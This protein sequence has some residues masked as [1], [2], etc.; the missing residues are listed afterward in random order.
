MTLSLSIFNIIKQRKIFMSFAMTRH[1]TAYFL[2]KL[3]KIS[4]YLSAQEILT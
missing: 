3:L 2:T 4:K 1:N